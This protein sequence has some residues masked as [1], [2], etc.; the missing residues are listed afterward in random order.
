MSLTT[1]TDFFVYGTLVRIAFRNTSTT[2]R[3]YIA[4]YAILF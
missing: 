2:N 1:P 4:S 3:R